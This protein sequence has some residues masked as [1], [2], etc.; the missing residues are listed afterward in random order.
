MVWTLLVLAA[1]AETQDRAAI[2]PGAEEALVELD[3]AC[4]GEAGLL[5]GRSLSGPM[6]VVDPA[7]REAVAS[8]ADGGGVLTAEGKH[9]VGRVP[10]DLALAN[11][12]FEWSGCRWSMVLWPLPE[13]QDA[14]VQLM[15]H[16]AWHRIQDELGLPAR[17]SDNSHLEQASARVWLRL[18]WRALARSLETRGPDRVAALSDA[19]AFRSHRH[20]LHPG[21]AVAEAIL[22]LNEGLA[23]YTG[24]RASRG[25]DAEDVAAAAL[26]AADGKTSLTRSFAYA[27]GPAYG[28]LLDELRPD[29]RRELSPDSDLGALTASSLGEHPL[30]VLETERLEVRAARY[31][32]DAVR[33]QEG[34]AADER[35]RRQASLRRTLVD[36]PGLVLPL[37]DMSMQFDPNRV[38][39]LP[40]HGTVYSGLSLQD[41]WGD[42]VADEGALI[43]SDYTS[44]A[45][46]GPFRVEGR[47]VRGNGW[48]L[49]LSDGW[50]VVTRNDRPPILMRSAVAEDQ[51][52]ETLPPDSSHPDPPVNGESPV[53]APGGP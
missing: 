32:L 1:L 38:M 29:W 39:S 21:A 30:A 22:E 14:R 27:S 5:W 17:G 49:E 7:S 9:F 31:G 43:S 35:S 2:L 13:D 40:P 34:A 6:L 28:L 10:A 46:P 37:F 15:L 26:R 51:Q 42:I 3:Q 48:V 18:E 53:P 24:I 4:A 23:E 44:L 20:R 50:R 41:A 16:E 8:A 36:E 11:T 33:E 47:S 12:A 45:V 19:L 52:S 25:P